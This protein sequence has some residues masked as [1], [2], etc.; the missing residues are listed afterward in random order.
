MHYCM[1]IEAHYLFNS[2]YH[3]TPD[4]MQHNGINTVIKTHLI[5]VR[6]YDTDSNTAVM[7]IVRSCSANVRL[8]ERPLSAG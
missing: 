6:H 5:S 1:Y 7:I 2:I 3:F 4:I 8:M